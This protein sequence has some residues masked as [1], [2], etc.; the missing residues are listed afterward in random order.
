MLNLTLGEKKP[1]TQSS[2]ELVIFFKK[3]K[4]KS[5]KDFTFFPL[6]NKIL[7]TKIDSDALINYFFDT[8]KKAKKKTKKNS[9]ILN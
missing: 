6:M 3:K 7:N 5:H 1:K 2:K 9:E 8:A 4:K